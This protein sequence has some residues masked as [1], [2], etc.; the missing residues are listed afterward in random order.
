MCGGTGGPVYLL[1]GACGVGQHGNFH[2]AGKLKNRGHDLHIDGL[3]GIGFGNGGA[4]GPF[5]VLYFAAGPNDEQD[6]RFGKV[7]VVKVK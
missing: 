7:E 2:H 5:D 3:W 4:S 1:H 6:G